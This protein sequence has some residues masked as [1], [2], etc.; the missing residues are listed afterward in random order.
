MATIAWA[1]VWVA[2][3]YAPDVY[4]LARHQEASDGAAGVML[5]FWVVATAI[6]LRLTFWSRT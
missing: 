6:L 4:Y 3:F 1:I 2:L 5:V